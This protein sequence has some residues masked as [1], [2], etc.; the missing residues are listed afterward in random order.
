MEK[1]VYAVWKQSQTSVE[2]FRDD[3]VGARGKQLTLLGARK[4][5]VSVADGHVTYAQGSVITHIEKP[6]TAVVSFW[7]DTH[8]DRAPLEELI[9]EIE[10]VRQPSKNDD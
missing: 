4:L 9:A 7:L 1:L 5:A 2:E 3:L 8:L 10:S 6:I